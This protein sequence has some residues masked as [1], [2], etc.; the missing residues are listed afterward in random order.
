M[1]R[2]GWKYYDEEESMEEGEEDK[3]PL[4]PEKQCANCLHW[5]ERE[6]ASC[7]WCGKIF[8]DRNRGQA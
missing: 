6:V 2:D 8:G 1:A 4:P 5:V 7:P 3:K